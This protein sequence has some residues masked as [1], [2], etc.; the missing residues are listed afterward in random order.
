MVK[1][2]ITSILFRVARTIGID[3]AEAI[4]LERVGKEV[5]GYEAEEVSHTV[6]FAVS[7]DTRDFGKISAY[8]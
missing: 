2:L 6:F 7:G 3:I 5:G 4:L 8:M 1:E